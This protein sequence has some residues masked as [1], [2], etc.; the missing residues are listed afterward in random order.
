ME[1]HVS[2]MLNGF[3]DLF[4]HKILKVSFGF[5]LIKLFNF[6]NSVFV[7]KIWKQ[8]AEIFN[9]EKTLLLC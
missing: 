5:F 2:N 4:K 3:T 7:K 8:K 6:L 1:K 9:Y